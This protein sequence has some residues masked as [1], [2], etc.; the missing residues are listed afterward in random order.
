MNYSNLTIGSGNVKSF[1]NPTAT[2]LSMEQAQEL[3]DN[4]QYV[5]YPNYANKKLGNFRYA[6]TED[7]N[8]LLVWS[9][10]SGRFY[11]VAKI[12]TLK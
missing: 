11:G 7:K 2:D 5:A 4:G 6:L 3:I 8:I 12:S 10:M 1:S 9:Q